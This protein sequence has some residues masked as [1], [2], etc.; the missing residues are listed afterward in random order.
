[1]LETLS[2]LEQIP[3]PPLQRSQL[4]T[5]Q[6]NLGYRCNLQCQHCHVN[7]GPKRTEV[8]TEETVTEVIRYLRQGGV[9]RLDLTGG[10]PEMNPHFRQLVTAAREIGVEVVDRCN[11]VVMQELPWLGAFLQQQQVEVVA[12]LPCYLEA[13][14]DAQRGAGSYRDSITGLQQLNALG[15]GERPE[16]RLNLVYNSQG[17]ALPPE[18]EALEA[19][20]RQRLLRDHGIRFHHLLTI[21]NMPINRFGSMLLSTGAFADYMQLLQESYLE[22]NLETV[23]CRNLISVNWQGL[24][25][26]CDFNQ[27]L[28]LPLRPSQQE[29]VPLHISQLAQRDVEGW[30]I[31]VK[32]HCYGC[33]AGQG[34]SCSGALG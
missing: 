29:G 24:L 5:L 12:S 32:G 28:D 22:Q 30:P 19:D 9:K 10:A 25:F 17:A 26:D 33:T 4:Q 7:A 2:H 14:V 8:M 15:Y 1:M 18:Q 13:N 27:L 16:L 21:T 20:Y 34:S 3:F 31:V 23:M 11:L 6:V